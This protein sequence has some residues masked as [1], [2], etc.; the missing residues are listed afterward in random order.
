MA[1]FLL[2][3]SWTA[4]GRDYQKAMWTQVL[5]HYAGQLR[6]MLV[7]LLVRVGS[8]CEHGWCIGFLWEDILLKGKTPV[9]LNPAVQLYNS[10]N[11]KVHRHTVTWRRLPLLLVICRAPLLIIIF[12][13]ID[14]IQIPSHL[15]TAERQNTTGNNNAHTPEDK[16][17]HLTH[18][19]LA[20][21]LRP[22]VSQHAPRGC[23]I[24]L[25]KE[26]KKKQKKTA[27]GG[28]RVHETLG[29]TALKQCTTDDKQVNALH[30]SH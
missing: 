2:E 1:L 26:K 12:N 29:D 19:G 28:I 10:C 27:Q 15:A 25:T 16:W 22:L 24:L 5:W 4:A 21:C 9:D 20:E 11:T 13:N 30:T 3:I 18:W 8:V 14:D 7:W 17:H 23:S 6:Q